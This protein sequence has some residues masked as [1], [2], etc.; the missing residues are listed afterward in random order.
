MSKTHSIPWQTADSSQENFVKQAFEVLEQ[1]QWLS[2]DQIQA[3]T[4]QQL[5]LVTRQAAQNVPFYKE[6][7]SAFAN[8]PFSLDRFKQIPILSKSE[9]RENT[10]NLIS[11]KIDR[12]SAQLGMFSSSGST[13][14][15]LI[16]Y[17][18]AKNIL[19]GRAASLRY[20]HWHQRDFSLRNANIVTLSQAPSDKSRNWAGHMRTGPG[21]SLD[22]STPSRELFDRVME[23][24]PHY[25]QTHPS[26]LKRLIEISI[27]Q[28]KKP[29]SLKEVR[30]FGEI[31]EPL[32]RKA[33]EDHWGC[34]VSDFYSTEEM[35]P[36]A[37]QCPEST[38]HHV[39][40]ENVYLEILDDNG[41][42]CQPG[43][44]GRI[45]VTQLRNPEM[46]LIRYEL[47]D[48]GIWAESCDCGRHLPSIKTIE[49]R[50]RNL[51]RLPNG[52]TFHP[53]FDEKIL[54]AAAPIKQYQ[55]IQKSIDTIEVK[56]VLAHKLNAE[57]EKKLAAAFNESFK[58]NFLYQFTYLDAFPK[59]KRNKFELFKSEL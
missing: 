19:L 6:R 5:S 3:N 25:I 46:P 56:L 1:S 36:I 11:S 52:D 15:P 53:V 42:D 27:E 50:V 34:P 59:E 33:C 17:R 18:G 57:E 49:G 20:H 32:I 26:S 39:Q 43:E 7:L 37:F 22:I 48:I 38:H 29:K 4:N 10:D 16:V 31:L 55:C 8:E 47:G 14:V 54:L 2:L 24:D 45:V 28:N 23:I 30:T 21:Y 9:I 35:G 51:V 41:E 44:R 58:N 12:E 13:G 40:I